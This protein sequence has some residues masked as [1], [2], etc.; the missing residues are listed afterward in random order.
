LDESDLAYLQQHDACTLPPEPLQSE[1]LK[2]YLELVNPS[3]PVIDIE[4]TLFTVKF[5]FEYGEEM[6]YQSMQNGQIANKRIQLLLFQAIMLA[7]V[8]F[9]STKALREAGFTSRESAIRIFFSRVKILYNFDSYTDRL[10]VIQSLLLMTLA[11]LP[12]YHDNKG[13]SHWLDLAISFSYQMGLYRKKAHPRNRHQNAVERRVWWMAV[14]LDRTLSPSPDTLLSR[15]WRIKH[16]DSDVE[17]LSLEDF[18]LD[19]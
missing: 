11:N 8:R 1:I 14:V 13:A 7:G 9:V 16:E 3:F 17:M 10:S 12:P 19:D 15:S 5:G 4:S 6:R 18:D 2:A